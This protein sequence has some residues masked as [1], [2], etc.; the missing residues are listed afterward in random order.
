MIARV[1]IVTLLFRS[2]DF[3]QE[4]VLLTASAFFWHQTGLAFIA[5]NRVIA[6]AFYA[7]SDSKTP[8]WAGMASFA[9][10]ILLVMA[11]A[12]R[13]KGPG[14]A[15]ALSVSSAVNTVFLVTAL[16]KSGITDIGK[17]LARCGI[18]AAKLL[19]FSLAASVPV[20]L[21]RTPV[22]A[23]FGG[24]NSRLFSFGIP[25]AVET[26]IFAAV[27][28]GLLAVFK[29]PIARNFA[30]AFSRKKRGPSEDGRDE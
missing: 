28:V 15:L 8:T 19:G 29:D 21:A 24:R 9:V 17:E 13:F 25:L 22:L 12:T 7:R 26:L 2:G 6:P 14:I 30:G 23:F 4:S 27:G 11:V 3:S 16:L 10:N 18:Y 5:S 1:E 20:L